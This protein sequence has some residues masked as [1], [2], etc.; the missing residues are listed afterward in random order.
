MWR[1]PVCDKENET[2]QCTDC[3][4]DGSQD[5][6]SYPSLSRVAPAV[7]TVAQRRNILAKKQEPIVQDEPKKLPPQPDRYFYN[8]WYQYHV[9]EQEARAGGKIAVYKGVRGKEYHSLP[10]YS[11][12]KR[13]DNERFGGYVSILHG[14]GLDTEKLTEYSDGC[15]QQAS[16]EFG[17]SLMKVL[18][19]AVLVSFCTFF[20]GD[21]IYEIG[22]QIIDWISETVFDHDLIA[23]YS[24]RRVGLRLCF[25]PFMF[26]K[27]EFRMVPM[28]DFGDWF[29]YGLMLPFFVWLVY[30]T[31]IFSDR[32]A[33]QEEIERRRKL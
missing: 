7:A 8:I 15:L 6:E 18:V 29:F 21:I 4:F 1:C 20:F 33:I 23:V 30:I 26:D 19:M 13:W 3:G 17:R 32:K 5:Y 28:N 24:L 25:P 9:T 27:G 31:G 2:M 11:D 12:I 16:Q 22:A 14:G 10:P